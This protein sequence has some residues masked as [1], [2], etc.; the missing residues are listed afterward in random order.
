[1]L[2]INSGI[3]TDQAINLYPNNSPFVLWKEMIG[4]ALT[5][6]I[7]ARMSSAQV[8]VGWIDFFY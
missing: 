4:D 6:D 3:I 7:Y 1:M 5:E 8:N 2:S